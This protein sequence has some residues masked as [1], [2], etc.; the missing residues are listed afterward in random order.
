MLNGGLLVFVGLCLNFDK[1]QF[2]FVM[3]NGSVIGVLNGNLIVSVGNDLYVI[4]SILYVGNDVNL[5]GKI[6]KIDVVMDI[7]SFVE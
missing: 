6:V 4:G 1:Q 7:F 3:N 5:V 2:L